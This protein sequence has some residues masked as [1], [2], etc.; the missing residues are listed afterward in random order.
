MA[1]LQCFGPFFPFLEVSWKLPSLPESGVACSPRA[2][3]C[4]DVGVWVR[5]WRR[6]GVAGGAPRGGP[7]SP[8]RPAE[9]C[10]PVALEDGKLVPLEKQP[11]PPK[12]RNIGGGGATT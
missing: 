6:C 9:A 1:T 3:L 4:A 2:G 10:Y 12:S 11:C 8:A 7:R 5:V